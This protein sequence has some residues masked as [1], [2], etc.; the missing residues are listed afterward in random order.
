MEAAPFYWVA[1]IQ[2]GEIITTV[3]RE[4]YRQ[5]WVFSVV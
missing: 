2:G 5:K 1:S 3:E 4:K